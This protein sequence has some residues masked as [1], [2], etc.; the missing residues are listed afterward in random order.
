M[1]ARMKIND[2]LVFIYPGHVEGK[3]SRLSHGELMSKVW[4]DDRA[5][6]LDDDG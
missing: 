3:I 2:A 1:A 5:G 4:L 6:F